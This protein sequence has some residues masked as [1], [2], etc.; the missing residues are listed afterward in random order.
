VAGKQ[1]GQGVMTDPDGTIY[2]G[3]WVAGVKEGQGKMTVRLP[4]DDLD[5]FTLDDGCELALSFSLQQ[6]SLV[7][8][9]SKVSKT[10][11][12]HKHRDYPL[13]VDYTSDE[14]S[15]RYYLAPKVRDE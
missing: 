8:A 6:L 13:R 3:T 10:V 12:V 14:L 4:L 5:E 2:E 11:A 1:D 9:Y 7:S 15:I